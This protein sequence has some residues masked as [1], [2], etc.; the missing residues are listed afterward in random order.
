[1][2]GS[3]IIYSVKCINPWNNFSI[4]S[5]RRLSVLS[6]YKYNLQIIRIIIIVN[7]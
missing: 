7:S 1:M 6:S 5:F 2:T 3:I 4:Y